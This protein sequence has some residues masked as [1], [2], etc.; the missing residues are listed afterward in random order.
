MYVPISPASTTYTIYVPIHILL[1]TG[2]TSTPTRFMLVLVHLHIGLSSNNAAPAPLLGLRR[3]SLWSA[4]PSVT[5][6]LVSRLAQ[7][8][9]RLAKKKRYVPSLRVT[10]FMLILL[11]LSIVC[12]YSMSLTRRRT[13]RKK[14][15][16]RLIVL[17]CRESNP[18]YR[19]S[20][21]MIVNQVPERARCYHYTTQ[22]A[23]KAN[24]A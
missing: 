6:N 21:R 15:T 7:E 4:P 2:S 12:M 19:L 14:K 10:L 17:P 5:A 8:I 20:H 1:L 13:K 16:S 3:R 18:G 24:H 22:D 23:C 11:A 9:S